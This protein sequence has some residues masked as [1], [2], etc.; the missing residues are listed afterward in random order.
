MSFFKKNVWRRKSD[1]WYCQSDPF[2]HSS[3][4]TSL[5]SA[6]SF[7][8]AQNSPVQCHYNV[9]YFNIQGT[10]K[11]SIAVF[12]VCPW[13]IL[14]SFRHCPKEGGR[15]IFLASYTN[16]FFGPLLA[17]L[18]IQLVWQWES[19]SRVVTLLELEK[20]GKISFRHENISTDPK[21][22]S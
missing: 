21:F 6:L 19:Q 3:S 15:G 10:D 11:C 7:L 22:V 9:I 2:M 4:V 14:F 8:T 18:L 1:S 13:E 16:C 20:I 17:P 5:L 12:N